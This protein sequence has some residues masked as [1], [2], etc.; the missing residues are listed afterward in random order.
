M[1]RFK[2]ILIVSL[3]KDTHVLFMCAHSHMH[4]HVYVCT[5]ILH[6]TNVTTLHYI[7]YTKCYAKFIML[8]YITLTYLCGAD[9]TILL[10]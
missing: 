9:L 4:L 8:Y 7:C 10:S 5:Y 1:I 3:L 2:S 6:R